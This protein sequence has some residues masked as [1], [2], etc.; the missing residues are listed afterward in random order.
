MRIT[1]RTLAG[2]LFYALG[3]LGWCYL[4][5]FM[6]FAKPVKGLIIAH[7]AG[8]LSFGKLFVAVV[9]GFIYLSLA[10]AVWCIG[11]MAGNYFKED[12]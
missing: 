6:I 2:M 4:G 3:V 12:D 1:W 10:G 7:L 11:Y 9:Q 8:N 5:G